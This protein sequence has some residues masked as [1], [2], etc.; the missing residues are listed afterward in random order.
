MIGR[1]SLVVV[2]A[3]IVVVVSLPAGAYASASNT[4]AADASLVQD[5]GVYREY[6]LPFSSELENIT[7]NVYEQEATD[8]RTQ[9]TTVSSIGNGTAAEENLVGVTSEAI[10]SERTCFKRPWKANE[11]MVIELTGVQFEN[12]TLRG[13]WTTVEF[14]HGEAEML[15]ITLPGEQYLRTLQQSPIGRRILDRM[16]NYFN[17]SANVSAEPVAVETE[18]TN[19]AAESDDPPGNVIPTDN[20]T[21]NATPPD[22][23]NGNATDDIGDTSENRTGPTNG[24]LQNTTDGAERA[25][26]PALEA[27]ETDPEESGTE[28]APRPP[29]TA[30]VTLPTAMVG[31]RFDP[32]TEATD[33]AVDC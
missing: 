8:L 16:K 28:T 33:T 25:A 15:T 2:W 23:G 12:T 30:T 32:A 7:M 17:L 18:R 13:P 9:S 20:A 24:S 10:H 5:D 26:E 1:T 19:L 4:G 6:C 27:N 14:G 11:T 21:E 29:A 22:D 31:R 3:A